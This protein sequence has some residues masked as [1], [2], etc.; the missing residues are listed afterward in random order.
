M[1]MKMMKKKQGF[2]LAETVI[3][4]GILV[5]L[6][7]GFMAVFAPAA[8]SI[9]KTISIDEASRLQAS[10]EMELTTIREGTERQKYRQG[11]FQKTFEWIAQSEERGS[12]I[13]V[14]KYR[15]LPGQTRPDGT[16]EPAPRELGISGRD[17]IVKPMVRR[18]SDPLLADDLAVV[19]GRAFFVKLRQLVYEGGG[20]RV[21][22]EVGKVVDPSRPS[23]DLASRPDLY[24]DA[25]VAFEAEYYDLPTTSI[26]YLNNTFD[27]ANFTRPIFARNLAVMR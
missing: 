22:D 21:S 20:L 18:V 7:T 6:I 1:E 15:A 14:Y 11:A 27:P 3:A 23:A 13:I 26:D 19:E 8:K 5:V 10:L 4:M 2:T 24:P 17:F 16:L 9:K 25:M 12:A